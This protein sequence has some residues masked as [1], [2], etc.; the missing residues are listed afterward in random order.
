LTGVFHEGEMALQREV[1][2]AERSARLGARGIRDHLL[3]QQRDF[4]AELPFLIVGSI[5]ERGQPAAS[6][7]CGPPG[8]AVAPD[9]TT[10]R[11]N[12]R[13]LRGDPLLANLRDGAPLG[14]LG[15]QPHTRRR[16]R[17]NGNVVASSSDG[18]SLAVRQSFGN[19]PKYIQPRELVYQEP[20]AAR[21]PSVQ[22]GLDE[23]ARAIVANADTFF[24]ASAHPEAIGSALPSRGVDVSHRGGPVGFSRFASASVLTTPDYQGNGLFNTLGNVRLQPAVGLLFIDFASGDVLSLEARA[25]LRVTPAEAESE[26]SRSVHFAVGRSRFFPAAAALRQ[27]SR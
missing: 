2:V 4:F 3:E 17:V 22:E 1:G 19:C 27:L 12:A 14:I 23:R 13:R 16:N 15:I 6:L 21:A 25:E 26:P 24:I 9:E 20:A 10:L 18:F 8:F 7:V 5:D 11:V